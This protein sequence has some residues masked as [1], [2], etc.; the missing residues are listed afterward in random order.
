[1][2]QLG[3]LH[4]RSTLLRQTRSIKGSIKGRQGAVQVSATLKI[5]PYTV[6]K[7]DTLASIA[8]KRGEAGV[9][10]KAGR[11]LMPADLAIACGGDAS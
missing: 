3:A 9:N 6:R 4:G 8:Q 2:H 5:R 1:M 7:G 11:V 10:Q